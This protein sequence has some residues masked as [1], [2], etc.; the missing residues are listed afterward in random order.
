MSN[1]N[2]MGFEERA[3]YKALEV[4]EYDGIIHGIVG[5]GLGKV[6]F[7]GQEKS[8]AVYIKVIYEVPSEKNG[9]EETQTIGQKI[10]LGVNEKSRC[11]AWLQSIYGSAFSKQPTI[12]YI[13]SDGLKSLLG[14][15]VSLTVATFKK[16]DKVITFVDKVNK[17]DPRLTQ[18]NPVRPNFFFNPLTP[19][20]DIF[21]NTLTHRT[22]EEIMNALNS[23]Q[24][25]VELHDLWAKIQENRPE[26]VGDV[27][28]VLKGSSTE[29][30][31]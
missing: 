14:K 9:S 7:Q 13:N 20:L 4:G 2:D 29:S 5:L 3:A 18:P 15:A 30:I 1:I 26:T 22:Q 23:E 25:P 8:P 11:Y 24:F 27:P 16:D 12:S 31:E 28:Q 17:L 19:D 6:E 21:E 10:K